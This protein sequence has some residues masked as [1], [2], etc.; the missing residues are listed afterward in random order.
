MP[1]HSHEYIKFTCRYQVGI[2]MNEI[3]SNTGKYYNTIIAEL[4]KNIEYVSLVSL[5]NQLSRTY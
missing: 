1:K 5:K 2:L 4:F 3:I